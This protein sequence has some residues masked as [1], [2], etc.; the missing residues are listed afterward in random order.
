MEFSG[1]KLPLRPGVSLCYALIQLRI[2]LPISIGRAEH[3]IAF[4]KGYTV[5][6]D[7]APESVLVLDY[8]IPACFMEDVGIK[9][10]IVL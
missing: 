10:D 6:L 3:A 7:L 4:Q 9:N 2:R 5:A 8:V 1:A